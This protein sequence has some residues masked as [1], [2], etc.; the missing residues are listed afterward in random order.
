MSHPAEQRDPEVFTLDH[1]FEGVPDLAVPGPVEA[2]GAV[3]DV[4]EDADP[5]LPGLP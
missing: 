4:P 2:P 5:A 1:L 3:D